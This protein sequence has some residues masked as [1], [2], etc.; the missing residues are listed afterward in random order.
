MV[1]ILLPAYKAIVNE[2]ILGP[3]AVKGIPKVPLSD[4]TIP[5]C[6]EEMSADSKSVVL[7]KICNSGKFAL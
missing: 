2:T 7:E 3:D 4:K 1:E 6:I 5:R